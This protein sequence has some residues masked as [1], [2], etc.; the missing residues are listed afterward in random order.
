MSGDKLNLIGTK[1]VARMLGVSQ[2]HATNCLTKRPD[3]PKPAVGITQ[4]LRKWRAED[5]TAWALGHYKPRAR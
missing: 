5:V 2:A 1:E 4:R 3:F